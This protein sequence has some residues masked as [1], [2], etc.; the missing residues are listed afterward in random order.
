MKNQL[1]CLFFQRNLLLLYLLG[2][3]EFV[4]EALCMFS[5][6]SITRMS[7]FIFFKTTKYVFYDFTGG[8]TS[9]RWEEIHIQ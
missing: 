4:A 9:H 1:F 7:S 6:I 5:S 3:V 8:G 2:E